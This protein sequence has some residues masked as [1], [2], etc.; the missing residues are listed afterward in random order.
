MA[1]KNDRASVNAR[2]RLLYACK[3]TALE[4]V[5]FQRLKA[6]R[7]SLYIND[8]DARLARCAQCK[9]ANERRAERIANAS[10][11]LAHDYKVDGEGHS[12]RILPS[13]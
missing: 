3:M 4:A 10:S 9:R 1:A 5:G 6:G 13:T 7:P 8:A 2:R 12:E 11:L